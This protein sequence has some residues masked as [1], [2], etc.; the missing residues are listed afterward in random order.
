[1]RRH[2]HRY[3]ECKHDDNALRCVQVPNLDTLPF[4]PL[5][6]PHYT[7]DVNL[8]YGDINS[9]GKKTKKTKS[10][11]INMPICYSG[12]TT[13]KGPIAGLD[14]EIKHTLSMQYYKISKIYCWN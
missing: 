7:F 12:T 8:S 4:S 9:P 10:T 5:S 14:S 13:D 11:V 1:M 6:L 2:C 3:A